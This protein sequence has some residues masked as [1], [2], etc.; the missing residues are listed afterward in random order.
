MGGVYPEPAVRER[1]THEC[2]SLGSSADGGLARDNVSRQETLEARVGFEPTNGGFA[3]PALERYV[4][5][6]S[7]LFLRLATQFSTVFGANCSQVVP[8]FSNGSF[9]ARLHVKGLV[10]GSNA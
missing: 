3:D 9:K 1:G 8:K 7:S 6:L 4:V 5:G 10:E 2:Q